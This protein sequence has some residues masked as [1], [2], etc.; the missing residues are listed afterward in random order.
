MQ[1][2][3]KKILDYTGEGSLI[4]VAL[5]FAA[6]LGVNVL[7]LPMG[8]VDDGAQYVGMLGNWDALPLAASVAD[9][10]G[11]QLIVFF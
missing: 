3:Y 2:V 1:A 10:D 11:L 7:L 9:H 5:T 4:P 6:V 8:H